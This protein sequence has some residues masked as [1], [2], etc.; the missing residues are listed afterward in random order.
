MLRF[1][2]FSW[3]VSNINSKVF[4]YIWWNIQIKL[5]RGLSQGEKVP[6]VPTGQNMDD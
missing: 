1:D 3:N 4:S 5:L 6:I 2:A